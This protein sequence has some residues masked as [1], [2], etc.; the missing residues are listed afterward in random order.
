MNVERKQF[1]KDGVLRIAIF[2]ILASLTYTVRN[3]SWAVIV[4]TC[5]ALYALLTGIYKIVFRKH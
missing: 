3:Y 4:L 2:V 1:I 5:F